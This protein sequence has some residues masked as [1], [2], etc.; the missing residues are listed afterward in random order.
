MTLVRLWWLVAAL[1][2]SACSIG[3]TYW[4]TPKELAV[5]E[6]AG[7]IEPE[8]DEDLF[9]SGIPKPGPYRV[10]PGD[11]LEIRGA[12]G[13]LVSARGPNDRT[14]TDIVQ[15]RVQD[16]GTVSLPLVGNLAVVPARGA[17]GGQTGKMLTEV[18]QA[19]ADALHPKL[20]A[21]K[22][23]IV[24]RV[25]EPA[26]VQV[27]VFGAV[28]KAGVVELASNQLSLFGALSAA[29]GIIKASN[30]KV[31]AKIIRIRRASEDLSKSMVLPVKGLNVPFADVALVGGE[32]VEVE[33][34]DPELF[35]VVGLVVKPGA[36]EYAPGQRI[37][38]MQAL[39]IAGGVD[40]V[41]DPPYATVFRADAD[42]RII[43]VTFGISG[44]ELVSASGLAIRP[45]DVIAVEHTPGS[46]TRSLIAT[47]FRAQLNFL[48][49][50][51]RG[52]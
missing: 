49:D 52:R 2:C 27:A 46:W 26:R 51:T 50:P 33:R 1:C 32:T 22:P 28:E 44:T 41:A 23:A 37:N 3:T 16:D 40:R 25:L 34:W 42:G 30:L 9:L 12:G 47:V 24:A 8:L 39:A 11:V 10:V 14:G 13:F 19:I 17:E 7:P 36:Y 31:G 20:L 5:F 4:P 35:T 29:G 48:V 6:K 15:V 38:L 45:G 21:Q 43:P 18:E